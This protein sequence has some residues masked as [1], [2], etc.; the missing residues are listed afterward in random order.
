MAAL[1]N[2]VYGLDLEA[3]YQDHFDAEGIF[4]CEDTADLPPKQRG[5]LQRQGILSL[6]QCALYNADTYIGYIGYDEC[7]RKASW[8]KT[9]LLGLKMTSEIIGTFIRVH[10]HEEELNKAADLLDTVTKN[11]GGGILLVECTGKQ[12]RIVFSNRKIIQMLQPDKEVPLSE[13]YNVLKNSISSETELR[14]EECLQETKSGRNTDLEFAAQLPDG[15]KEYFYTKFTSLTRANEET[16]LTVASTIDV[17]ARHIM[18][19]KLRTEKY[20]TDLILQQSGITVFDFNHQTAQLIQTRNSDDLDPSHN[21]EQAGIS[22]YKDNFADRVLPD[23][24]KTAEQFL[25]TLHQYLKAECTIRLKKPDGNYHWSKISAQELI[26]ETGKAIRTIGTVLDVNS[27]IEAK[28]AQQK[29][30]NAIPGGIAVVQFAP[31]LH[32]EY[33]TDG[34]LKIGGWTRE[35]AEHALLSSSVYD[36][37]V[38]PEDRE[39]F[40]REV[41]EKGRS[42]ASIN[43]AFRFYDTKHQVA[44][45]SIS[46]EPI[47]QKDGY[48]VYYAVLTAPSHQERLNREI[49]TASNSN[50][51]IVT[52]DQGRILFA[53]ESFG[54]L[55]GRK[56]NDLNDAVLSDVMLIF[57]P[58]IIGELDKEVPK[59]GYYETPVFTT[60]TGRK[61]IFSGRRIEWKRQQAYILFVRDQTENEK[62]LGSLQGL[63]DAL[64][65][66][67]GILEYGGTSL[68]AKYLNEGFY[69]L[70]QDKRED[71]TDSSHDLL[72]SV[73]DEDKENLH[74]EL[75][76]LQNGAEHSDIICRVK[77]RHCGFCWLRIVSTARRDSRGKLLLYCNFT[78][79]DDQVMREVELKSSQALA[80]IAMDAA[81]ANAWEYYPKEHRAVFSESV[82]KII[83]C[84]HILTG[85]PDAFISSNVVAEESIED[86]KKLFD[87]DFQDG[88]RQKKDLRVLINRRSVYEWVRFVLTPIFDREG[89]LIKVIVTTIQIEEQIRLQRQY[90]QMLSDMDSASAENLI[91]KGRYN[92]MTGRNEYYHPTDAKAVSSSEIV[93]YNDAVMKTAQR[94]IDSAK[95]EEFIKLFASENIIQAFAHGRK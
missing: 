18:E 43:A 52:R 74:E 34:A 24:R 7:I 32:V 19:E 90:D 93:S 31:D 94:C 44:W 53:S 47:R 72:D 14:I 46:A 12:R 23:D 40:R 87:H 75:Q 48:P 38:V 11:I 35:I 58:D 5:V 64:P 17:T 41:E 86:F 92:L 36:R 82:M 29:M 59:D 37:V 39:L 57:H 65:G 83:G 26:N 55:V 88:K 28:I 13:I 30:L 84:E 77:S 27:D 81:D 10:R 63:L 20:R 67:I 71:Y 56:I 33:C 2:L 66:G 22:S 6:L 85:M 95:K 25:Q 51:V 76:K 45:V 80:E 50:I 70:L 54:K 89:K 61:Y 21:K 1:Q 3:D 78:N 16:W 42:G 73:L 69:S 79:V 8:T 49:I 15:R 9:Q 4:S 68:T 60:R 62:K 91:A